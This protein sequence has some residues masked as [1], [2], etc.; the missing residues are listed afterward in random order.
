V[1]SAAGLA[2]GLDKLVVTDATVSDLLVSQVLAPGSGLT[3]STVTVGWQVTN[4]G[5]ATASGNWIDRVYLSVGNK[6][7]GG[8]LI[9]DFPASGPL[10][11]GAS[12]SNQASLT[13]P[14][15]PGSYWIVVTTDATGSIDESAYTNNTLATAQPIQV[16]PAY[17]ATVA[18][19]VHMASAGS[20]IPLHG[21]AFDPATNAPV[22]NVPVSIR[23]L[24]KG[25][26][27]VINVNTDSNG[28]FSAAFQPLPTEAG[29]YTV[30]AD[31]PGIETDPVQD[32][33]TLVGMSV[34]LD[35]SSIQVVSGASIS[36]ASD[37]LTAQGGPGD[38]LTADPSLPDLRVVPGVPLTA[39]A[40]LSNLGTTPLT[41]ITATV[42]GAPANLSVQVSPPSSLPG[43]GSAPIQFT[44]QAADDSVRQG[45]VT[46]HL[47]SAE[48]ASADL[49]FNVTV[50]SQAAALV[51]N[52][53]YLDV[54]MVR[55]SQRTISFTVSNLGGSPTGD[56]QIELPAQ[57]AW[58][59]LLSQASI[60]SLGPGAS[61]TVTLGLNPAADLPLGIYGG[62][63]V[64]TGS[65]AHLQV[66]FQFKSISDAVGDIQVTV[67]DELTY[68]AAGSPHVT[69]ATVELSDP[70]DG[71]IIA[72]GT[73]DASG[74]AT[75][76]DVREGQYTLEVTAGG[77]DL[78]RAPL[79]IVPGITNQTDV[80]L[81]RQFVSMNW[82]VVPGDVT[83][84]YQ[85]TLESNFE[86]DVPFPVVTID[87]PL[88][89]PLLIDG[90]PTQFDVTLT[91]HGLIAA[92]DVRFV[93]PYNA[94]YVLT[95]L[96]DSIGILPAKSS[97]TVPVIVS[98]RA[99]SASSAVGVVDAQGLFDE[100]CSPKPELSFIYSCPC[101]GKKITSGG[102]ALVDPVEAALNC[103]QS[104][105]NHLDITLLKSLVIPGNLLNRSICSV[106]SELVKCFAPNGSNSAQACYASAAI[107]VICGAV[108]DSPFALVNGISKAL[109]C[110]I[111]DTANSIEPGPGLG[112]IPIILGAGGSGGSGGDGYYPYSYSYGFST[113]DN[114][115]GSGCSGTSS[116]SVSPQTAESVPN[117]V[118]SDQ[119]QQSICATVRI[120]IDQQ[121]VMTRT[122][123]RG[124]L[125]LT[126]AHPD[127]PLDGISV[128]LD[129]RDHDGNPADGL[130]LV[131]GPDLS[132]ITAVD[133]TGTLPPATS[134]EVKYTFIPTDDAASDGPTQYF[135]GGT[136]R[137]I[138]DGTVVTVPLLP[139]TVTVFPQASLRVNYFLQKDVFGPDPF[140]PQD[141]TPPQ[142]FSL[143]LMVTNVGQGTAQNLSI[144][145]AQPQIVENQKGL[146]VD[147]KM[148]GTQVGTQQVSPSLTVDLGDI[149]PG[150]T[151]VA[152]F[153]MTASL[154]GEFTS[155]K[156]TFEH[157]D[158]LN[159]PRTSLIQS[160]NIHEMNHVVR[161]TVP[162]D[163]GMPDF[164]VN[165][166]P[167]P[168]NL[169]D[170]LYNSDGSVEPVTAITTASV[171]GS[172][173]YGNLQVHVTAAAPSGYIYLQIP[174]P[175][176]DG[177]FHLAEVV[178]SDG[179]VI[180]LDDN[181]W[182]THRTL[183]PTDAPSYREDLF[184]LF[185]INNTGSTTVSYTLVYAKDDPVPPQ[186]ANLDP[187]SPDPRATAVSTLDVTFTKPI[188]PSS[189]TYQAL[190]LSLNGGP[191]L[192][193]G[194][195]TVTPVDGS[196]NTVFQIAGLDGL[197][198][199]DG[200]YTLTVDASNVVDLSFNNG[201]GTATDTWVVDTVH[202]V[203]DAIKVSP[204]P[205][206]TPISTLEVSFDRP[207]DLDT[208][209]YHALS[210]TLNGGPNLITSAVMI[211]AE[212]GQAS[213]YLIDGLGGLTQAEGS[214]TLTVDATGVKDTNGVS[215]VGAESATWVMDTTAP[216]LVSL[217]Q[218]TT[219]PRNIV[220][221]SLDVTFTK[222]IDLTNFVS[223]ALTLTRLGSGPGG[224]GQT[225]LI[226][227]LVTVA[228]V[229]GTTATYEISGFNWVSGY[230][231]TYTL[232]FNAAG[233]TDLAGNAGTA[234]AS[235]SW[236]MDTTPPAKPTNLA[237][238]PDTGISSTDGL[239]DASA[240]TLTGQISS[241]PNQSVYLVDTTTG[242]D[243]G[244]ATVT[245]TTFTAALRFATTG[246]HKL[247]VNAVDQAGNTS[248]DAIFDLFID[249]TPPVLT[250]L[251]P[252]TPN[253]RTTSISYEQVTFSKPINLSTLGANDVDLSL[254][255]GSN[256]ITPAVAFTLVSGTTSTYQIGGLDGLTGALGSYTLSI[257]MSHVQDLAGNVGSGTS[258]VSWTV[259]SP[260]TTPPTSSVSPLPAFTSNP[261]F[262]VQWSGQDNPGGSGI[263]SYSIYL[264]VDGGAFTAWQTN[265]TAT[266]AVYSGSLG[267][268]YAF[269]SRATDN[270]GNVEAA[271][272]TPD[273]KT[274]VDTP[275]TITGAVVEGGL[276]ER[277]YVDNLQF[278]FSKAVNLA[279]LISSGAITSVATLTNLGVNANVGPSQP[280]T[281][282][283]SQFSY[284]ATS[285]TL[286]WSL[287][288]FA[289]TNSS[290]SDGYYQL[291]INGSQVLDALGDELDGAGNGTPGGTYIF[292]FFRLLGDANGDMVVDASTA[293]GSDMTLVNN[294]LGTKPGYAKWNPNAD[295][296]RDGIV[297]TSDR[298]IVS[299]NNGH[300]IIP[301]STTSSAPTVAPAP[302]PV[303][304]Q[305]G[306]PGV[307]NAE[308]SG[309]VS[310]NPAHAYAVSLTVSGSMVKTWT[311][312][313]AASLQ[314]PQ[315]TDW[316]QL[317]AQV[318]G[319]L[320]V[321]VG[322]GVGPAG[323]PSPELILYELSG[324]GVSA[325]LL[326][327]DRG[328]GSAVVDA[329]AGRQYYVQVDAGPGLAVPAGGLPYRL[330][331]TLDQ[332]DAYLDLTGVDVA[333][334]D[335]PVR[336]DGYS[337]AV[338]DT[339]IDYTR[340]DLAG[341]VIL[342]PDL[343][344]GDND[345]MDT[346]GHGTEVAGIIA[347]GNGYAPG[348]APDAKLIAL[349]ITPDGSMT[350]SVSAI[351]Q[352]LQW[353]IDHQQQDH[354]AAVNLSFGAG[355]VS[356]GQGLAEL[357]PLFQK[358]D[359]EDVF[360]AAAAGNG[361]F[362]YGGRQGLSELAASPEVVS[363]GAVWAANVGPAAWSDGARDYSTAPD[364]IMSFSQ[365]GPGLDLLA[366]GGD[367]VN[368]QARGGLTVM[369]GT[370]MATPF[371]TGAAV[372]V[373]DAL[374][375]LGRPNAPSDILAVL[376]QTGV[377]VHDTNAGAANVPPSG[378]TY[379]R[380]D[381]ASA[382]RSLG[383]S[384]ADRPSIPLLSPARVGSAA[385]PTS[386]SPDG[387]AAS[388]DRGISPAP[389]PHTVLASPAPLP[390]S[391]SR[392]AVDA[393]ASTTVL[394]APTPGPDPM[395]GPACRR[396][397][398][399]VSPGSGGI[400]INWEMPVDISTRGRGSTLAHADGSAR[401]VG[402]L[403]TD[404]V[405]TA[406]DDSLFVGSLFRQGIGVVP[407]SEVNDLSGLSDLK[408][409]SDLITSALLRDILQPRRTRV[410]I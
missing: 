257:D 312:A 316:F 293:S 374:D 357:E 120:R 117:L 15:Y 361:Y 129:I 370:S 154:Q 204:N 76:T 362:D 341:R 41:G 162:S 176:G 124:T 286:T 217:E 81:H 99:P 92:Q 354:I 107:S 277:S 133:G 191:N 203:L 79:T 24:T 398:A 20:L 264:S 210:L 17:R 389:G 288:S 10:A 94:D 57:D 229:P 21:E 78:Y 118:A 64:L 407:D 333:R 329:V 265:T 351:A 348:V 115:V 45:T 375:R 74:L 100:P 344:S 338:I 241:E 168:Q 379:M 251:A 105:L 33:F 283:A 131:Q 214:Y 218:V 47:T 72:Q 195:V 158:D 13:L 343:G 25:T 219:N 35:P 298:L 200:S 250:G 12:Y 236:V 280:V 90:A 231:G 360:I 285:N 399:Q 339:G 182:T 88:I 128:A 409:P 347:S 252:I 297:N 401:S 27:R 119:P 65:S 402:L 270:A 142:P 16:N 216:S 69:G 194:A 227:N 386:G 23:V 408:N 151:Q 51:A 380:V 278:T 358:L 114:G 106:A 247:K 202:P 394:A 225:N 382:L 175:A 261:Q 334:A 384:D 28:Q 303:I 68:Y 319:T 186:I 122:V 34:A 262:T 179:T 273:T 198:A 222:P 356:E 345:P 248:D 60:P 211:E 321:T 148:I 281:L 212:P 326:E 96:V 157:T 137:Y 245:G 169:P 197:T 268:T 8:T 323:G 299:N 307:I 306:T 410:R 187:V 130:F 36:A 201:T 91:N 230:E 93:V 85:L 143:G 396:C 67:V 181:A 173:G 113:G 322:L 48:G 71:T 364:Q 328:F 166:I 83:D 2:S 284:N 73:T 167:D 146:L 89:V 14:D 199:A 26:R 246:E 7:G 80:F 183:H 350:A 256:L 77:H 152:Q 353:V 29:V 53:G 275:P 54:G 136:L 274:T 294:A 244:A 135:I 327:D 38:Q 313:L 156:A 132:G 385:S 315:D 304:P 52:P 258:S 276:Y 19:D 359:Q 1:A 101:G 403:A 37:T 255:G 193:T 237:I 240:V 161:V 3:G 295:L 121:A 271:H 381:V 260:D 123:F 390:G 104:I 372:L 242:E 301:P 373:R 125:D 18:A 174:D 363:V 44:L 149:A 55:G 86:T 102:S 317:A 215:G 49:V 108:F 305:P 111:C 22:A 377:A 58:L 141:T 391:T 192:I 32:Q 145:S 56:L 177:P 221:P 320:R 342:G 310:D 279:S 235:A 365:R 224:D 378:L 206:N 267:H 239:T 300:K 172:I 292:H 160:L 207:I 232:T 30:G 369:S 180:R 263:A 178:R 226:N 238:T 159:D 308:A 318:S 324:Q 393:P 46:I 190:M 62:S 332:Y 234:S 70:Q 266:S 75:F 336:G 314:G 290:L 366:P 134:G 196:N 126:N 228:L 289:A 249:Q 98:K 405:I 330:D 368:L 189:L 138:E 150:Q 31:Y 155:Y 269:Y 335:M 40:A 147:F 282:S 392:S 153:L 5:I 6:E 185:D 50:T 340:P 205:R 287:E 95:P 42:S 82:D 184:H 11:V 144:T 66:P 233:I 188:A 112:I 355:D 349:K 109:K 61:A 209:D 208:F 84:H 259:A 325:R 87:Q 371:V 164:L 4:Q 400:R 97:V 253:P 103:L 9:G 243:L 127:I 272:A 170:T 395:G 110:W 309:D 367:I 116:Q 387:P 165:D 39:Q 404:E 388:Q 254:N 59:S 163:D 406:L 337:V 302:S 311:E 171:D 352:A 331:F 397:A 43:S 140:N 213:S 220:V 63:L 383:I 291:T 346:V 139:A 223:Q 296:N 376:Q